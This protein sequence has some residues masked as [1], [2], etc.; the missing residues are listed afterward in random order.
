MT[1]NEADHPRDERGRFTFSTGGASEKDDKTKD[2]ETKPFKLKA[3]YFEKRQTPAEILYGGVSTKQKEEK[4]ERARLIKK[5]GNTLSVAQILYADVKELGKIEKERDE[6]LAN[7]T[8]KNDG[9]ATGFA[10]NISLKNAQ[11]EYMTPIEEQYK[12][13][14]GYSE[15][16]EG[17]DNFKKAMVRMFNR[18]KEYNNSKYDL[19]GETNLGITIGT[20]N[21]YKRKHQDFEN[22]DIKNITKDQAMRI[23][24]DEYWK[25]SGADKIKDKDLAYVHF[26]AT[27]NHGLGN[28]R[29][30]LKESGGDF[31]KYIEIRKK[32]YNDIV[33]NKPE[34]ERHIRGWLNRLDEI[35]KNKGNLF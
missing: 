18:E 29:R 34:Q 13:N 20:L 24:Y 4:D 32:Y 5:L 14:K 21:D 7:K 12:R 25:K 27:V 16:W 2:E 6:A 26:D 23:Y 10:T 9:I 30:F 11:S 1:W 19:G 22:V 3:E 31:D 35:K 28:S 33:K 15:V 17:D 8:G